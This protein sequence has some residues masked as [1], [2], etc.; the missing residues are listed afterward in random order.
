MVSFAI[1]I[2]YSISANIVTVFAQQV[3]PNIMTPHDKALINATK[4]SSPSSLVPTKLHL[5]KITSPTKGQQVPISKDLVIQGTSVTNATSSSSSVSSSS[6]CQVSVIVNG[7]KPYQATNS[8]GHSTWNYILTSKYT[9][10]KQGP[11]NKITARYA[12]MDNPS[13]RSFYN[14][15]VTGVLADIPNAMTTTTTQQ[16]PSHTIV[17]NSSPVGSPTLHDSTAST[18]R[19][20][21]TKG[22][23]IPATINDA[24]TRSTT[25]SSSSY[26]THYTGNHDVTTT[27]DNT[28]KNKIHHDPSHNHNNNIKSNQIAENSGIAAASAG[29]NGAT[30]SAGGTSVYAGPDGISIK[31]GSLSLRL[32]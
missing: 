27:S 7:I 12:C 9:T 32:P 2:F 3:L 23:T 24:T 13:I 25:P 17:R 26:G 4:S 22:T 1:M 6:H 14:V 18:T 11:N 30:A 8:T 29:P 21:S 28:I 31:V 19:S 5:V 10:L 16:Q 20:S 15:N